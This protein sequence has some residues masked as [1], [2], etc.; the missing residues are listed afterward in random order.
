MAEEQIRYLGDLQRLEVRPGDVFVLRPS[1]RLSPEQVQRLRE[2]WDSL[3]LGGKLLVLECGF[4]LGVV[5]AEKS[6]D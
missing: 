3:G 1:G 5:S 4:D 6:K 2:R